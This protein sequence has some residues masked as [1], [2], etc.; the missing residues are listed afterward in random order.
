MT[1]PPVRN[2]ELHAFVDGELMPDRRAAIAVWLAQNPEAAEQVRAWQSQREALRAVFTAATPPAH[3][4][5]L[6]EIVASRMRRHGRA[7]TAAAVAAGVIIGF[8][9]GGLAGWML[10]GV[11][12]DRNAALLAS[13]E[14]EAF[15]T[16]IVYAADR[17]HPIEVAA[18]ERDHLAQWLSNR[19]DRKV[20]PPDL[21]QAGWHLLGGRLLAT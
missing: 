5:S 21:S 6:L 13:L 4:F 8:G 1:E 11:P 12:Q 14:Q 3:E 15:A 20:A 7:W 9:L 18:A 19:L 16:H 2:D 17:R 10:H